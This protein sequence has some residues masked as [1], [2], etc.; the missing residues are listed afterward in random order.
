M[1]KKTEG[2]T[3]GARPFGTRVAKEPKDLKGGENSPKREVAKQI[4]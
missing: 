1:S 2:D 3:N 4:L